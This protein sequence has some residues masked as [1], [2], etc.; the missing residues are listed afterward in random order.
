MMRTLF[1]ALA[2]CGLAATSQAAEF[3]LSSPDMRNGQPLPQVQVYD[4]FGCHGENRSPA[5]AWHNPPAGTQSFA[6]TAYDPDAPSGSGWWH[7][8]VFNI[9]ATVHEL[10]AGIGPDGKGLPTGAIQ[11]RTDFGTSGFGGACPPEGDA[12]HRYQFT[13]WALKTATLPLDAQASGAMVGFMLRA[14]SIGQARLTPVF[15]R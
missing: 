15:G 13:V 4:G 1:C 6:V 9:P 7:W 14:N 8:T 2:L 10:P 3:T 5:L 11:G 12:P